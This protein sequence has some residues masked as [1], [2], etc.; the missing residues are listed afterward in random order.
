[1]CLPPAWGA[2]TC[3]PGGLTPRA[4]ADGPYESALTTVAP[5]K[6]GPRHFVW[7]RAQT[8][9]YV[10]NELDAALERDGL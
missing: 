7:N 10:L 3:R 6:S 5:E 8:T 2:T 1:M 9:M 4:D